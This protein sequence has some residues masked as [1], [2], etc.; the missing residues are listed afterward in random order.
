MSGRTEQT[1]LF[2]G[3]SITD[4]GRDH[5]DPGSLGD[6]WVAMT[7]GVLRGRREGRGL[8]VVNRGIGG[9]RVVDLAGRWQHDCL[10][11]APDVVSVLIGVNETWRRYD[12][13]D[14]TDVRTFA[15]RLRGLLRQVADS[16]GSRLVLA[17]PFL[18]P[19]GEVAQSW[20]EDLDPKRDAVRDLAEEFG[21]R[22]VPLDRAMREAAA[23]SGPETWSTDGIHP[24]PAGDALIAAE[25]L[26]AVCPSGVLPQQVA[27][28]AR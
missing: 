14:P 10:D 21:A 8:T 16:C 7:A 15:S 1:L 28:G 23:R 27:G 22:L 26:A 6:G 5:A 19:M 25:W 4:E 3:D 13:D 17:E 11:L 20:R 24:T 18:L 9:N 2:I 12:S